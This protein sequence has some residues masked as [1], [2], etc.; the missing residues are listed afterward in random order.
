VQDVV[1]TVETLGAFDGDHVTGFF[2]HADEPVVALWIRTDG[3]GVFLRDVK[4]L[5]T[6]TDPPL[7]FYDGL[8]QALNFGR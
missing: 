3:A 8:S 6:V 2:H 4:A 7:G 5:R 1:H